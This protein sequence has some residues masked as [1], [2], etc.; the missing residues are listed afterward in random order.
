VAIPVLRVITPPPPPDHAGHDNPPILILT[1]G[2]G[3][4]IRLD[5]STTD[6]F[7]AGAQTNGIFGLPP[8]S[9]V[10]Y[11]SAGDGARYGGTRRGVRSIDVNVTVASK[12]EKAQRERLNRLAE[13]LDDQYGPTVLTVICP[14]C[15]TEAARSIDVRYSAGWDGATTVNTRQDFERIPLTLLA[16]EP[17]FRGAPLDVKW[18]TE[19]GAKPLVDTASVFFPVQLASSQ[20]LGAVDIVNVGDVAAYATWTVTGPGGPVTISSGEVGFTIDTTLAGGDVLVAD[21]RAGTLRT[22]AGADAYQLF[23]PAP[24]LWLIPPKTST[25]TVAMGSAGAGSQIVLT[26][27][28]RFKRGM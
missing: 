2:N 12:T 10:Q 14:D 21:G 18:V 4:V 20:V 24:K 9:V 5:D 15:G 7:H 17:Y 8:V 16:L 13:V 26:Y 19:T 25:A 3:D 6:G 28:P 27:V 1:G 22:A 11:D 23:G